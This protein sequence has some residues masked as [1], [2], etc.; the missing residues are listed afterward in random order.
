M[1]GC[2]EGETAL[3]DRRRR[4]KYLGGRRAVDDHTRDHFSDMPFVRSV[5]EALYEKRLARL[6]SRFCSD[7]LISTAASSNLWCGGENVRKE[8]FTL[9][10][11]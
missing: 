1:V 8:W 3:D 6:V 5:E 7:G 2:P 4:W 10:H 11:E 9:N